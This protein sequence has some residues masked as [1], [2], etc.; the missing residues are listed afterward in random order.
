MRRQNLSEVIWERF[1]RGEEMFTQLFR[2]VFFLIWYEERG[3]PFKGWVRGWSGD[4]RKQEA[5]CLQG[6]L[7]G[8]AWGWGSGQ[9]E[10]SGPGDSP[11]E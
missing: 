4:R 3:G 6:A 2:G 8:A 1:L 9:E 10:V 11:D 7:S 5:D